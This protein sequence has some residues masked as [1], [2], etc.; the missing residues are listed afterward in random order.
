MNELNSKISRYHE[1]Y[2]L[3]KRMLKRAEAKMWLDENWEEIF[4]K[5]PTQKDKEYYIY[6]KTLTIREEMD[7]YYDLYEYSL[8]EYEIM[9]LRREY[10]DDKEE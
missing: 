5:K 10:D 9:K 6:L 3:A 4:S 1:Q 7:T 8:R 2:L